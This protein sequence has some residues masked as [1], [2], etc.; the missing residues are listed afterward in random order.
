M[1]SNVAP[2]VCA[3]DGDLFLW[4]SNKHGQLTTTEP[5]L[6]SPTPLRQSLLDGQK[7]IN[8]WSG[9]TH[10]IAQTGT[11]VLLLPT[12]FNRIYWTYMNMI[13]FCVREW[14]SLHLGQR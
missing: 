5:F 8:V 6:S 2:V 14:Q 13:I 12:A 9:W 1:K 11:N 10:I 3:G 7:V 4:G